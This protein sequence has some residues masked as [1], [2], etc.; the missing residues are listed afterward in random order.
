MSLVGGAAAAWPL[1]VHAQQARMPVIG[2]LSSFPPDTNKKFA[3]AFR[4]GLKQS[5][6]VEGD[7]VTIVVRSMPL[8][9]ID[10]Q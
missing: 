6:F 1:G 3:E 7:N 2:Y 10:C 8:S 4:E 9:M 5:G